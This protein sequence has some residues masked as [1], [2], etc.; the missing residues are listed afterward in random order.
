MI[1]VLFFIHGLNTGGA[2]TLLKN[3]LTYIDKTTFDVTLLCMEHHPESPYEAYVEQLGIKTIYICDYMPL[4]GKKNILSRFINHYQ[5]FL[6]IRKYFRQEKAD[7][8][9]YHLPLAKYIK[10]SRPAYNTKIVYTQHF[11]VNRWKEIDYPD[12]QN[13]KWLLDHY[14]MKIIAINEE[15]KAQIN[16]LF[17]IDDTVFV[18]NG[19]DISRYTMNINRERK[20]LELGI[21]VDSF[22]VVHVGRF[23]KEKNQE[24][25]VKIFAEIK[26][27]NVKA[28]LLM[29]GDGPEIQNVQ[30]LMDDLGVSQS[31]K[32]ISNRN[33]ISEILCSS[34]AGIFPSKSEGFG[35]AVLE[36][37]LA[38]LPVVASDVVPIETKVSNLIEY[39]S[40]EQ[41]P[42]YWADKLIEL[43]RRKEEHEYTD[44]EKWDI[45]N[46]VK[47]LEEI[48]L[49]N[50]R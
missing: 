38:K 27:H 7:V 25:L 2:E 41:S 42:E 50:R 39:L 21:P 26:K 15:M 31:C 46:S 43:Y 5:Y 4:A 29:V 36:M 49:E 13:V 10:F 17:Q 32:I 3:Y 6:L 37:Q 11:D 18:R 35:I 22:L 45:R 48:Y 14:R 16:D 12:V 30:K 19:V 28:F 44:I 1:K 33:D 24:F 34:D 23:C 9:H 40:L 47:Q 20:R 8:I